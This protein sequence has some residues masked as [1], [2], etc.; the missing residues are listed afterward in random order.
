MVNAA[1]NPAAAESRRSRRSIS[2]SHAGPR[3]EDRPWADPVSLSRA[4][5]GL[6]LPVL[7]RPAIIA[8]SGGKLELLLKVYSASASSW[9]PTGGSWRR[10]A[11]GSTVRSQGNSVNDSKEMP[12]RLKVTRNADYWKPDRPYL[13][14]IEYTIIR[15]LSTANLA[16]IAGTFDMTAPYSIS[17]PLF[18]DINRQAPQ[19]ICQVAPG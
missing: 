2:A 3:A 16:F 18:R 15:S 11:N 7:P 1:N 12:Q 5:R 17:I 6:L 8:G 9:P 14:G 13:D 4:C 19:A 10:A